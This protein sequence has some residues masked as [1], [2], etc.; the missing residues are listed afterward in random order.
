DDGAKVA[1][2]PPEA[3]SGA[4]VVVTMLFDVN[5]VAEVMQRA[6]AATPEHAVW[7]QTSTVGLAGTQRLAELAGRYGRGYVDAP[8]LGTKQPAE[9]GE[10][11]VLASG[12][13]ELA[14]RVEPVFEAIGNKTVWVGER[15]GDGHRLK[16]ALNSWVLS[17]TAATGQ[18]IALVRGLGVDPQ[19]FLDTIAGGGTDSPYAQLKGKAMIAGDFAP[20]FGLAGAVKDS[21]LIVNAL[22]EAGDDPVLMQAVHHLMSAAADAGHADEDMAAVVYAF[23]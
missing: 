5:A 18:A 9:Q 4:D 17:I 3:V 22:R 8:V 16:L 14:P 1:A 10:L 20:A 15:V 13:R 6:L 7:A 12:P 21:A 11:I 23:D 19:L 2:D